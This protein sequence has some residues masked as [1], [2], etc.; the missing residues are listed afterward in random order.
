VR[1]FFQPEAAHFGSNHVAHGNNRH[2]GFS[3]NGGEFTFA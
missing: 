1:G 3:E 2:A